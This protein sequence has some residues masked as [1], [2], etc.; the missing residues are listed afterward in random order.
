MVDD[1]GF[2]YLAVKESDVSDRPSS[3]IAH[4]ITLNGPV[5]AVVWNVQSKTWTFDPSTAAAFLYDFDFFDKRF[6]VDRTQ[7]EHVARSDL[8]TELPSED[9]L[10]AICSAGLAAW[11]EKEDLS[12]EFEDDDDAWDVDSDS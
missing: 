12:A 4:L 2:V 8:Q 9:A 3:L 11:M 10:R 1:A 7:A 6:K 5:Q